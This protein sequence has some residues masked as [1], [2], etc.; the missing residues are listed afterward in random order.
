MPNTHELTHSSRAHR[1]PW[2]SPRSGVFRVLVPLLVVAAIGVWIYLSTSNVPQES[3]RVTHPAGYS[4]VKPRDWVA[5]MQVKLSETCR[6]AITLEPEKWI[7]L[8]P[9]IWVHRLISPP[10]ARKLQDSG[11]VEGEFQGHKAWLSQQKPRRRI[12]RVAR[13][14][15]GSD[16]YEVGVNLPGLEGARIDDW[17]QFALTFHP[18]PSTQAAPSPATAPATAPADVSPATDHS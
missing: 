10:D 15:V 1:L 16:W 3:N 4:I 18:A 12:V 7:S 17:W 13:F 2:Y 5:K 8:E 6:D 14:A 9:S 11:F